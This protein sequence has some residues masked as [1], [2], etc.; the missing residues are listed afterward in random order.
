MA[1]AM[2]LVAAETTVG[3][4]RHPLNI[5]TMRAT[6]GTWREAEILTAET[7][8]RIGMAGIIIWGRQCAPPTMVT[9]ATDTE[10]TALRSMCQVSSVIQTEAPAAR[11]LPS[12]TETDY[13]RL[14]QPY[15]R[16][17]NRPPM[18]SR[19][20]ASEYSGYRELPGRGALQERPHHSRS[21]IEQIQHYRAPAYNQ[22][23][24][25]NS[26]H[27]EGQY[28]PPSPPPTSALSDYPPERLE[29]GDWGYQAGGNRN[30]LGDMRNMR[31]YEDSARWDGEVRAV[32]KRRFDEVT[33]LYGPQESRARRRMESPT[34]YHSIRRARAP[35][36]LLPG[37]GP[38]ADNAV[39]G[40][41]H[42]RENAVAGPSRTR[43]ASPPVRPVYWEDAIGQ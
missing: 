25:R 17:A 26:H 20:R 23:S 43:N 28:L 30:D 29:Y 24:L 37:R 13:E 39:A 35:S 42:S 21:R 38:A 16:E 11:H 3:H 1:F 36:I 27:D 4:H 8:D 12:I 6:L 15:Q 40:P 33:D 18:Q 7:V 32:T 14:P 22:R 2:V 34:E 31:T 41:S 9:R 5:P 19:G 10:A